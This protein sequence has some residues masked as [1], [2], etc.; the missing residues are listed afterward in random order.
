MISPL[1]YFSLPLW[2]NGSLVT[3]NLMRRRYVNGF[4]ERSESGDQ[5]TFLD[6]LNHGVMPGHRGLHR[7][8]A[9]V[10]AAQ[11]STLDDGLKQQRRTVP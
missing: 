4:S 1:L 3:R 5:A 10:L 8:V 2:S 11:R 9:H 6:V 7:G